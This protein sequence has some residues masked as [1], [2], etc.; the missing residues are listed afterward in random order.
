MFVCFLC[1][2]TFW[3]MVNGGKA[4]QNM[5]GLSELRRQKSEFEK[6]KAAEIWDLHRK[7]ILD[8]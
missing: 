1:V 2:G 7:I 5:V 4:K 3:N 8:I 6:A